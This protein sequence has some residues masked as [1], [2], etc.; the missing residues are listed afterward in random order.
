MT[1]AL[2]E[3][4]ERELARYFALAS[5]TPRRMEMFSPMVD[6]VWHDLL[7]EREKYRRFCHRTCGHVVRHDTTS[8]SEVPRLIPW[9][10]DYHRNYGSLHP[11]WFLDEDGQPASH[12][13]SLYLRTGNV[14]ASWDCT[15]VIE[16]VKPRPAPPQA[17]SEPAP[18]PSEGGARGS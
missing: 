17:P 10:A 4:A 11:V 2:Q 14:V 1:S 7:T 18:P 6:G 13:V 8:R 5:S 16:T 9:V 12:L 15:P 3:D